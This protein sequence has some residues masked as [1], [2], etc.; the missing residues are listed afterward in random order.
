MELHFSAQNHSKMWQ[1]VTTPAF[2][3]PYP[4]RNS[5]EFFVFASL[6]LGIAN[7]LSK[8]ISAPLLLYVHHL[9]REGLKV[10]MRQHFDHV[11]N[12]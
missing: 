9:R 11:P 8:A 4:D 7:V 3:L 2:C 10:I 12:N 1:N 5:L 6:I